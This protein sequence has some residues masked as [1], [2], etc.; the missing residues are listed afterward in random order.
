MFEVENAGRLVMTLKHDE[1]AIVIDEDGRRVA[2]ILPNAKGP[3]ETSIVVCA[4][5]SMRIIRER[6]EP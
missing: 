3:H 4:P 2:A 5:R 1:A 6:R